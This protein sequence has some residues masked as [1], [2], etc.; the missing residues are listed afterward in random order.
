MSEG[1]GASGGGVSGDC[2]LRYAGLYK[3]TVPWNNTENYTSLADRNVRYLL[4]M[5]SLGVKKVFLY[6]AH[7][8]MDF[9]TAPNFL[10]F[11][12]ADGSPHPMLA[13]HS[14]MARRLEKMKFVRTKKLSKGLW[15]Y[16][17]SDGKKSVAAVSG[18]YRVRNGK[19]VCSLKNAKASD[20]YGNPKTLPAVYSGTLFYIEAPVEADLLD[21][22]LNAGKETF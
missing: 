12:C 3:H 4:S 13:A 15:A 10:V 21:R 16:L 11:F 5:L 17:F 18:R 1:Q 2:S 9:S 19:V 7:C 8:Y 6:S 22:S 20:L 14:A